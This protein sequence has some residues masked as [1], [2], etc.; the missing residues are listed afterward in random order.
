M[1]IKITPTQVKELREI[2]GAGFRDCQH[3]LLENGGEFARAVEHL[4]RQGMATAAKKIDRTT[5]EGIIEVYRHHNGSLGVLL[6]VNCETDFAAR[7]GQF[8]KFVKALA[9]HIAN[10]AP[11]YVQRTDIPQAEIAAEEAKQ[12]E[13]TRLEGKTGA[14]VAKIVA[15]RMEKWYK[16]V[17]LMEQPWL[18]DDQLKVSE[19]VTQMIAVIKE[20]IVI[21]R[22]AR[23]ALSETT[24]DTDAL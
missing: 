17:V 15:G 8:E 1:D 5:H 18:H 12:Q 21:Q 23:F 22:F 24:E 7:N 16:K 14:V 3:A 9:L 19:V 10:E 11:R 6:E 13:K 4:H 2:T 20:N